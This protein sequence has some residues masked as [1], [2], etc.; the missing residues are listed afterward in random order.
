MGATC[1]ALWHMNGPTRVTTKCKNIVKAGRIHPEPHF[2]VPPSTAAEDGAA[3][4][5]AFTDRLSSHDTRTVY[6][7]LTHLERVC[8]HS[9]IEYMMVCVWCQNSM[10]PS[11]R[12][13]THRVYR[14]ATYQK[15]KQVTS[16]LHTP[17]KKKSTFL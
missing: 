9:N 4:T 5:G 7:L 16:V 14:D 12:L 8:N 3:S 1:P 6:A 13:E 2:L 10:S 11:S 15:D 17:L